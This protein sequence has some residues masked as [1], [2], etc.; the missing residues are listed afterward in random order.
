LDDAS[1]VSA[2]DPVIVADF[3]AFDASWIEGPIETPYLEIGD[4]FVDTYWGGD[5]R[6]TDVTVRSGAVVKPTGDGI[7]SMVVPGTLIVETDASLDVNYA[8]HTGGVSGNP[9]GGAPAGVTGS[10]SDSG[11]SHGGIGKP[12]AAAGV[13]GEVY[14]SVYHPNLPG[15]GGALDDDNS[16]NGGNGAGVVEI[17]AGDVVL[18]GTIWA[19]GGDQSDTGSSG[20][21]GGAVR[22]EAATLTGAGW[23]RA[24]GGFNRYCSSSRAAGA[25]GGGR[26]A[27]LVDAITGFVPIDQTFVLGGALYDCSWNKQGFGGVGTLYVRTSS[28]THGDLYLDSGL[29]NGLPRKYAE[30]TNLPVVGSGTVGTASVDGDDP[31]DL[32]IE[33]QDAQQTFALGVVGTWLRIGGNDYRVLE[34]S[35]DRR[36]VL[37]EGASGIVSTGDSFAGVYKFDTVTLRRGAVLEILDVTEVGTYDVDSD[38]QLITP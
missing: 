36:Q 38:S 3:Q 17:V 23:I 10:T 1:G 22:I 16:G 32:W 6:A 8:G 11:G 5:V 33:P 7:L 20:G 37:L 27:L 29:S 24:H 2:T 21:A 13:P 15:G 28:S 12:R 19:W 9:A 18:D 26:I 14:D 30:T 34:Q 31:A 35:A 25:G 4:G